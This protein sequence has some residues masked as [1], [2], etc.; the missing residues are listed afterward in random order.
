MWC[1]KEMNIYPELKSLDKMNR[2]RMKNDDIKIPKTKS[3]KKSDLKYIK[4]A[5]QY[6]NKK[7]KD[8]YGIVDHFIYPISRESEKNGYYIF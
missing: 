6:V 1:K 4:E 2:E 3:N 5:T 7:F 8:N